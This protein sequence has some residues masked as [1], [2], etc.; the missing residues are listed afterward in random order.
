MKHVRGPLC[1]ID[2]GE[3]T[4][5]AEEVDDVLESFLGGRGVGTKLAHDRIPFDAD[6]LG[7]ENRLALATG[8]LQHSRMSFTGRMSATGLSP[9]TD[10][11][12]SSNAG[13]FLSRNFTATGYSAVEITG[14]SDELVIVHVRDG[15][16]EFEPVP[17]LEEATVSETCDYVAQEHGLES[18]HTAVVGPAGE[19]EVRFAS[20]MTSRER[21]FGRGGLGAVLGS[22]HVKAITFDGDSTREV[23]IPPLQ[24]DVHGEAAQTDHIMK[25]QGTTSV[26]EYANTVEALPTRYFSELSYEHIDD[27]S[28]DRVEEKKYQK[29]TCSACAFACKLPTRDEETGLETEGPEYETLMAFGPNSGVDDIVDVMQSNELCDEFG[30]DTISAGDVVAAYLASE[31]EFGNVE[32]IHDLVEKIAYREGIGDQL[33]DG[34]D[35]IHDDLGVENWTVKGME[36]AAHDGRTL[37]GQ[38]LAFAT[39]N[40]GADHMYGEFYPYEYPLVDA[41]DAF[42]KTGL[43][44]KPPKLVDLEN[45]NAV[46]DSAVLCKFSRDFVGPDRLETLLDADYE[47]LLEVGGEVVTLERHFNNQRGFDRE[48]DRVPYEIP[49]FEDGLDEYY[50][51]RGWNEDGTVPDEQVGGE[52][53]TLADD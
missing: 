21:A 34:I 42:D 8:P 23:E 50:V 24:T 45:G 29:G 41:D 11:L 13:G 38:G 36:F 26:T 12:L 35:R 31:D 32:L 15:G 3:R 51:E 37:N 18:E 9:L 25:R 17:D 6:P 19:N 5:D 46:K 20:I 39:A 4:V 48:D 27:I 33:A 49:G 30:L 44:G 10:G 14:E 52:D 16:V 2:V 40:R 1:T 7:P 47:R 53:T 43:E 22:K 28:G